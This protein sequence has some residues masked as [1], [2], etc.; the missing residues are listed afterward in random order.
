MPFPIHTLETAPTGSKETLAHLVRIYGFLPNLAAALAESPAALKGYVAMMGVFD[1]E[2]ATLSALERQVV[3]LAVSAKNRCEYCT[4]AHGMLASKHGMQRSEVDKL[5]QGRR[6]NDGGLETLRHFAEAVVDTRGRVP[7]SELADF[8]AAG[9]T[10]A[11][12]LEVVF[13]VAVKTLTN[14]AHH[15]ARPPV[16]K[17]FAGFLPQWASAA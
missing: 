16:N 8:V 17:R 10:Q 14:Y 7:D 3:L 12:V 2:E 6:L 9:F 1:S 15:I 13:G 4:A 11:Q 5:A